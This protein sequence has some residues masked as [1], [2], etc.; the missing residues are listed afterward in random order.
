[1][2][3]KACWA[4]II[5]VLA[6]TFV[7]AQTSSNQQRRVDD[8]AI[9]GKVVIPNAHDVDQRIEV[10]LE[11]SALQVIQTTYTDAS[12]N[13]DFRSLSP[14]AYYIAVTLEGYEP[15]H[16]LVEIFNNF[17]NAN[18]TIFLSKPAV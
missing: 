5:G 4:A 14:G 10:K 9:R 3:R 6:G 16:Q 13:F 18:V 7:F 1:M 17:G 2:F 12:G 11:N 8:Y 15:V